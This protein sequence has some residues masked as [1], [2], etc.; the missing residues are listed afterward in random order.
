MRQDSARTITETD[1]YRRSG[2]WRTRSNDSRARSYD[3]HSS[4]SKGR[5]SRWPREQS[6]KARFVNRNF[7]RK[8]LSSRLKSSVDSD[9]LKKN[10]SLRNKD[11]WRKC[12]RGQNKNSSLSKNASGVRC[13]RKRIKSVRPP[14]LACGTWKKSAV[15][16]N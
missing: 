1:L 15:G 13:R 16:S 14:R 9:S 4:N 5:C 11:S 12:V 3:K 2:E 10:K 8:S 7:R 6:L